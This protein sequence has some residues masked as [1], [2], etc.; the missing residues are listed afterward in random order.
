[1][2]ADQTTVARWAWAG[3]VR[4][5]IAIGR[6]LKRRR[7][8]TSISVAVPVAILTFGSGLLGLLQRR[9]PQTHLSGGSKDMILAV[10]GLLTLLL[11]LVL[12]T[13]VGNTYAFF[14][15]QKSQRRGRCWSIRRLRNMV[16]ADP[17]RLWGIQFCL[18]PGFHGLP[19]S[20]TRQAWICSGPIFLPG[21]CAP[22][23]ASLPPP[24]FGRSSWSLALAST[25]S[26]RC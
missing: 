19:R 10:I 15:T 5:L 12:G 7:P 1:M 25:S 11:A 20:H 14:A 22:R 3:G 13:L 16:P 26:P 17:R 23:P 8:V 6:E 21:C 18:I 2:G 4:C 24:S 9:L